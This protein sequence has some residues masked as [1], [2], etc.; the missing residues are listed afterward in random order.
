MASDA[1]PAPAG[2]PETGRSVVPAESSMKPSAL[3]ELAR[4]NM[5]KAW[6]TDDAAHS[7]P[8]RKQA[9]E[10]FDFLTPG[11]QWEDAEKQQL[12]DSDRVPIEFNRAIVMI[13]AVAGM[14]IN[15]RHEIAFIPRKLADAKVD[16]L[17]T[18]ASKWMADCCDGE[19]EESEAFQHTMICGMGWTEHRLDL[20]EEPEG[21]YI[22]NAVDP[23]EMYWDRTARK[24]NLTDARRIA[25]IRKMP[26]GDAM[27]IFPGFTS[28][29]LDAGWAIGLSPIEPQRSIEER[30]KRDENVASHP[31]R[32]EV[33]IV[34]MQWWE[35]ETY[36]LIADPQ[37]NT[38]AELTEEKFKLLEERG[39]QL[40]LKFQSVKMQKRVYR[41]V[42]IGS[43]ILEM[44]IA[45]IPDRFSFTAITGE[46][47][48]NKGT[49]FGLVR[50]MRDPQ[51]WANKWMSQALHIMNSNA[52]GGILA[53]KSAFEDIAQA[54]KTYALPDAITLLKDGA[55]SG[56]NGPKFTKKPTGEI[57]AGYFQMVELAITALRDVTGVNLELLGL[58]DMNQPGILEAQRKQAG[59]TVLATMFDSLRRMRK[60]VGRIRLHFIQNFFSDGRLIRVVGP[61][62]AQTLPLLREKTLGEYEVVVDETPTSPNQKQAN[63]AVIQPML[64]LFKEQLI[65]RPDIFV[66]ILDYSPLP[67]RVVEA[68]KNSVQ[69]PD[70][71]RE[72]QKQLAEA[73]AV[74]K[75]NRDQSTAEMQNAKAG[76]T[77]A[78]ALYDVAMAK[79]LLEKNDTEGLAKHLDAMHR[80][81]QIET[82]NARAQNIHADTKSKHIGSLIDMLSPIPKADPQGGNDGGAPPAQA[83]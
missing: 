66:M 11:G 19:D 40:G 50:L 44:D 39:K 61:E 59:M 53:E 73:A 77:Q 18:G 29:E 58:K 37:T 36:Y 70:P 8:W 7:S 20:E 9:S 38:K 28:D 67:S 12:L 54:E 69:L 78:T 51:K 34:Q 10:D 74:A 63:W 45:P 52:K 3:D 21:K 42:F 14:E 57:P 64:A 17:L 48:H 26:L 23:L 47:N 49:W 2:D 5:F 79:N 13:K 76:A 1:Q 24:K 33:A 30:R 31:D 80:A 81:A 27:Q 16:E 41:Q 60:Q 72:K 83:A 15:G 65:A 68:I 46:F 56:P 75:I 32:A 71:D 43:K 4:L 22:E 62:G 55:L 35:R 6:F 25:R 82:E